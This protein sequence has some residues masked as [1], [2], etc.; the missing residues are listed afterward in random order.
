MAQQ[1][2]LT[3]TLGSDAMRTGADIAGALIRTAS[4]FVPQVDF[5]PTESGVIRDLDGKLVGMFQVAEED[6]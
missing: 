6:A 3:I 4:L 1:F 5:G 2:K